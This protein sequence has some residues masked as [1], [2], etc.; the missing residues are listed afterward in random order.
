MAKGRASFMKRERERQRTE[1]AAVKRERRSQRG[2]GESEGPRVATREDLDGYGLDRED[3]D[4]D[5]PS[6]SGG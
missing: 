5:A 6:R 1:R 2:P 3:V 4:G